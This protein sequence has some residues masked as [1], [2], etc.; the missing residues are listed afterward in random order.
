MWAGCGG[1]FPNVA[2]MMRDFVAQYQGNA[3]FTDQ[4][5]LKAVLWSTVRQSLL[6][7][8]D[9][10]GFHHA[11]PWPA[12]PPVRWKAEHFHVGSNAGFTVMA[13]PARNR[14]GKNRLCY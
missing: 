14:T 4:Y 5:F 1:I 7:H 3:R 12:H 2:G 9:I 6:S 10:F 13:G 11:E 8:D